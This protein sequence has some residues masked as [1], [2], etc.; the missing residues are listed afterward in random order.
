MSRGWCS[1]KVE[2]RRQLR[3]NCLGYT[4]VIYECSYEWSSHSIKHDVSIV[5]ERIVGCYFE[6]SSNDRNCERLS[7]K[8]SEEKQ[9]GN[10]NF[11]N[12]I[13]KQFVSLSLNLKKFDFPFC[14]HIKQRCFG[15]SKTVKKLCKN[16]PFHITDS[17]CSQLSLL[18]RTR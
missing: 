2:S 16:S 9:F 12:Q 13:W 4:N 8:S 5:D 11:N 15:K 3:L 10:E 18:S 7:K 14:P 6:S 1:K 17:K